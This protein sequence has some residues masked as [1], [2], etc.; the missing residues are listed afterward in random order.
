[1]FTRRL[2]RSRWG[3]GLLIGLL[4]QPSPILGQAPQDEPA[5]GEKPEVSREWRLTPADSLGAG[6]LHE[7]LDPAVADWDALAV[8]LVPESPDAGDTGRGSFFWN[9]SALGYGLFLLG[10]GSAALGLHYKDRADQA[11]ED[12]LRTGNVDRMRDAYD[13][14]ERYDRYALGCWVVAEVSLVGLL[15]MLMRG[16]EDEA[17]DVHAKM[18]AE[19]RLE[20]E[21]RF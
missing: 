11:Y 5:A 18:G 6:Y 21:V 9:R 15:Y 4:I 3:A 17:W 16:P 20:V 10:T 14:A 7:P 2:H 1:V 19:S 8:A 12:Y 13:R